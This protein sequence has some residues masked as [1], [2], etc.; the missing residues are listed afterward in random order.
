MRRQR[1][2]RVYSNWKASREPGHTLLVIPKQK[3]ALLAF[4]LKS[5]GGAAFHA[6]QSGVLAFMPL[7]KGKIIIEVYTVSIF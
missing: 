6:E 2:Q 3:T 4:I 7:L 1:R 5:G